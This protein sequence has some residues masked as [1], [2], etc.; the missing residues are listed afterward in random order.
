[1]VRFSKHQDHELYFTQLSL[2]AKV[3]YQ[4]VPVVSLLCAHALYI[5]KQDPLNQPAWQDVEPSRPPRP[6]WDAHLQRTGDRHSSEER[7]LRYTVGPVEKDTSHSQFLQ[8]TMKKRT[9]VLFIVAVSCPGSCVYVHSSQMQLCTAKISATGRL[10]K[11]DHQ[12]EKSRDKLVTL[13][14]KKTSKE[15]K[16]NSIY[17]ATVMGAT[18]SFIS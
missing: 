12:F 14:F 8:I 1:M 17:K 7:M 18:I 15:H 2:H 16:K 10:R 4:K 5:A 3:M 6:L 11:E 13:S 9:P